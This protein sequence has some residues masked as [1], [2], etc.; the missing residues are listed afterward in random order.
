MTH[1]PSPSRLN[2]LIALAQETSSEKRR[3]LLHEVTDL[4]FSEAA[5]S[6]VRDVALFDDVLLSLAREME[7]QVRSDLALRM[8]HSHHAPVGLVNYLSRDVIFVAEPIL[9]NSP[10]LTQED[11]LAVV[12]SCEQDHLRA[13]SRRQDL[14][15]AVSGVI[16]ERGDDQTLDVLL[17][18][19]SAPLSRASAEA[20][21][22]R[23]MLNPDL[24]EA[25]VQRRNLPIDLLNEMY[26]VVEARMREM[27]LSRNSEL[28]PADVNA[29]L[30][31]TRKRLAIRDGALPAD[32]S[33][34]EAYVC[35]L[36][37][38]GAVTPQALVAML[39]HGERTR[40]VV[41]LA[42]LTGIDFNTARGIIERREPDGLAIICRA[43]DFGLPM[44]LTFV[45]L[46]GD[47]AGGMEAARQYAPLYNQL[48]RET[49]QRT[50]R[51]WRVRRDTGDV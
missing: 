30:E 8:A 1:L 24:H 15:E 33:D 18:N 49:A 4:F 32:L 45:A 39:R 25:V 34:A 44:F 35:D 22:D 46:I 9:A 21:I 29:A 7:E 16:V 51:F 10:V 40:F 48:S 28:D 20:V 17:R 47:Q 27:I 6:S 2:D 11:L 38:R 26:F 50:M 43:S 5:S 42:E 36:V 3:A 13:V 14:N 19:A 41:A 37:E 12:N 23:A 31:S